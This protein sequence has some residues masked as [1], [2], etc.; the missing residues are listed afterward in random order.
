MH[1]SGISKGSCVY[2]TGP[3]TQGAAL[4]LPPF[5]GALWGAAHGA[6]ALAR[7]KRDVA[8]A[9]ILIGSDMLQ[10]SCLRQ[11]LGWGGEVE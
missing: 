8:G 7:P 10:S 6:M 4:P 1:G 5:P 3:V 2:S 9:K 11:V